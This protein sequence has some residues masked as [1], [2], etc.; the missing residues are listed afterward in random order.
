LR[1]EPIFGPNPN[2]ANHLYPSPAKPLAPARSVA[3]QTAMT[4]FLGAFFFRA[5]ASTTIPSVAVDLAFFFALFAPLRET[6]LFVTSP[7]ATI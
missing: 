3:F 5:F 2:Q 6:F 4:P 1:N 7:H